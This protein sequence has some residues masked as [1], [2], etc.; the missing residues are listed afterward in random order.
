MNELPDRIIKFIKKHHLLTLATMD[1]NGPW[2]CSC[3]Y[4]FIKE[5]N[6]FVITSDIKT[7]HIQ[8]IRNSKNVAGTIAL[9]TKIIGK[10]RGIQFSGTLEELEDDKLKIA[11]KAYLKRFP[12]ARLMETTLWGISLKYVKMTDNRL[13]FGKKIIWEL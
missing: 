5:E 4:T 2:C 6:L 9:E 7:K 10:I 3:F 8:N 1:E 11:K 13:G 12:I